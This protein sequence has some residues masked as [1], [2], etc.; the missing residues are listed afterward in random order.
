MSRDD[1]DL[2][3]VP[4]VQRPKDFLNWHFTKRMPKELLELPGYQGREWAYR[5]TLGT[6]DLL[7]ANAKAAAIL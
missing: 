2:K 7:A 1:T 6:S 3:P 4:G 5:G